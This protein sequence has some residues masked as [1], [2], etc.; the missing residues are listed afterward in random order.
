[1]IVSTL[2]HNWVTPIGFRNMGR[3][4]ASISR[5]EG[6]VI[7]EHLRLILQLAAGCD[8]VRASVA[9]HDADAPKQLPAGLTGNRFSTR[10]NHHRGRRN[11]IGLGPKDFSAGWE[12]VAQSAH[13]FWESPI[14]H[15]LF[16][17]L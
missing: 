2:R 7:A 5:H 16:L 1:M 6:A 9:E 3:T 11:P 13:H 4:F 12:Y 14:L 17:P 10:S 8:S 15:L